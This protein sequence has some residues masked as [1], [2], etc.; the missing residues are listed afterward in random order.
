MGEK[1]YGLVAMAVHMAE[2]SMQKLPVI[3][4]DYFVREGVVHQMDRLASDVNDR[5]ET[6]TVRLTSASSCGTHWN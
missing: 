4:S 6:E 3:F 1:D 2:L 5:S